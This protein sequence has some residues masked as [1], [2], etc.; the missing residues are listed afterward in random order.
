MYMQQIRPSQIKALIDLL[1]RETGPEA[2]LL[3]KELAHIMQNNPQALHSVIEQDFHSSL[4]AAF[5][6]AMQEVYWE[7][8]TKQISLFTGKIN[9]ELEEALTLVTRFVNPAITRQEISQHIDELAR[10][11]RPILA[12]CTSA[13]DIWNYL[14]QF[15]FHTQQYAVLPAAHD[16]KEI[17]F[18]RFLQKKQGA[19]LCMCCLY[20][21]CAKRFGLEA[22]VVD[23]AGR[24]LPT[25]QPQDASQPLFA[26]PL[27][28]GRLLTLEDCKNYIFERNLE[29]NEAF[30]QPLSSRLILRRFFS[31]MIFILNKLRDERRLTFLRQYMDVLKN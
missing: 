15:F 18:G 20:T 11:L 14:G 3:K 24:V 1:G 6:G 7:D 27:E 5:V 8:L 4:P 12:N 17:S 16:I 10:Q 13:A 28:N 21:V 2:A 26:D 29:W 30:V 31:H 23:L 19:A 25:L 9:P 22:G